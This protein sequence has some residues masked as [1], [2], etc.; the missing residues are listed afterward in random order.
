M[1]AFKKA[2]KKIHTQKKAKINDAIRIITNKSKLSMD[3]RE[4]GNVIFEKIND[5]IIFI[6]NLNL[7]N[8][9]WEVNMVFIKTQN[10]VV[11]VDSGFSPQMSKFVETEVVKLLGKFTTDKYLILYFKYLDCIFL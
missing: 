4:Y 10:V 8:I 2:Y 3:N 11:A 7:D 6:R 1:P 5:S 9:H